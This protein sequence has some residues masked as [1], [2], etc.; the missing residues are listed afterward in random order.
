M[1]KGALL[2]KII[3]DDKNKPL[4]YITVEANDA[5]LRIT[6]AKRPKIIGK[7]ISEVNPEIKNDPTD[8]IKKYGKSAV[9]EQPGD[10]DAYFEASDRYYQ[11]STSS[12]KEGYFIAIFFETTERK[13]VESTLSSCEERFRLVADDNNAI[14]YEV[15]FTQYSVK[16]FSGEK[17]LGYEPGEIPRGQDWWFEQIHPEDSEGLQFIAMNALEV[18]K[19]K[20]IEY[21]LRRKQGD[22]IRVRD[23]VKMIKDAKGHVQ[24]LIG[25]CYEQKTPQ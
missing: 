16:V 5:Y 14:V 22:Y 9:T 2:G 18:G 20:T 24:G 19:D 1:A 21:R 25:R 4:D 13:R 3:V 7:K 12:P 6:G 10:F 8:W 17:I 15:N 11:V 23:T